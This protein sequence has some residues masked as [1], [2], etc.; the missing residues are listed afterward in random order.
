MPDDFAFDIPE[1]NRIGSLMRD[2]T[3][4]PGAA[5]PRPR[6]HRRAAPG[7]PATTRLAAATVGRFAEAANWRNAEGVCSPF[8]NGAPAA[9]RPLGGLSVAA[10]AAGANWTN[11]ADGSRLVT[12]VV[13]AGPGGPPETLE[14]FLDNFAWD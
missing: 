7:T 6:T 10:F 12:T 11:A 3:P 4:D 13:A 9:A 2:I 5:H 8:Q 14:T 1:L